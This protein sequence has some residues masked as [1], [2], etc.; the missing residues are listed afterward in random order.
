MSQATDILM[1]EHRVIKRVL[2]ALEAFARNA[3]DGRTADRSMVSQFGDFFAGFSDRCHHGKEEDRLFPAMEAAGLPREHG[4]LAVMRFEHDEGRGH[5]RAL[6]VI[7]EGSGPL[8]D[9]ERQDVVSHAKDFAALL[10]AHIEK[11]DAILFP[12]A[13]RVVPATAMDRLAAEFA[14]FEHD[15]MGH[16]E[17]ERLH[18]LADRL[19]AAQA[20]RGSSGG[21]HGEPRRG[22]D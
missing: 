7:G 13:E 17:H 12:M 8:S 18:A 20:P 9:A 4:P 22:R 5:V 16:G 6:R 19:I 21:A 1:N 10:R 3:A 15:V 2:D 14:A 11:E